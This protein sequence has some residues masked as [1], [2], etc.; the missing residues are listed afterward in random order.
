MELEVKGGFSATVQEIINAQDT[1]TLIKLFK[2]L[3]LRA[4]GK[5]SPDGRTHD[6]RP[7]VQAEFAQTQAYADIFYELATNAEAASNFVKGITPKEK[8]L[9][10]PAQTN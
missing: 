4:Y 3:V 1:P 6:K 8:E 10:I 5:K 2:D 7:E 9:N